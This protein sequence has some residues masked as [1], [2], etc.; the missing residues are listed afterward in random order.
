MQESPKKL[1]VESYKGVRDFYPEDEAVQTYLFTT[2]KEVAQSF[3]Y[4]EYNASILEPSE[5]Y[6]SKGAE[7]EE[8]VNEQTYTFIDRGEREVTLRP[9]MTPSLARMVAARRRDLAFPLRWY[10]IPNVFRYERPQRGRLREHWQL[11][12]DIF[13]APAPFAEAEI[14]SVAYRIM[15]RLGATEKD[16]VI[17]LSSRTALDSLFADLGLNEEKAK[18]MRGLL[19]RKAKIPAAEFDA[20][21]KEIAGDS[22]TMPEAEPEDVKEVRRLLAELGITNTEYDPSV[23]RG[24]DYYTGIVF[25]FFDT[26]PNNN[27]AV[28]GGGRYDNLLELFSDDPVSGI[29]F[30]MGD[31]TLRD[32]LETRN[33]LPAYR[34]PA[35]VY[36]ATVQDSLIPFAMSLA[37]ELRA[38]NVG[39]EV[40]ITDRKLADQIKTAD[41]HAVPFLIVIGEDEAVSGSFKVRDLATGAEHTIS[42]SGLSSFFVSL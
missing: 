4:A 2:M 11:N 33:L 1:S 41:K 27:R 19:D 38:G 3:G 23:V 15:M 21:A 25:E 7:N 14:I 18:A 10:S 8:M 17:K 22:F 29:G 24:F 5:L 6:K 32:F 13:G 39:V 34:A 42:R 35:H 9:E 20:K 36:L 31:V 40:N 26:D 37:D 30:G 16:F 28:L 12:V